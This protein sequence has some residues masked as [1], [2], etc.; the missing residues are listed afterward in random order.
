MRWVRPAGA[1]SRLPGPLPT[2]EV[3]PPTA[4]AEWLREADRP[5]ARPIQRWPPGIP[6][7]TPDV[8]G[9]ALRA[10]VRVL[11]VAQGETV[12]ALYV[13]STV[14]TSFAPGHLAL[15]QT[16]AAQAATGVAAGRADGRAARRRWARSK[17]RR[18][19]SRSRRAWPASSSWPG[20]Y[21]RAS[22]PRTFP[23]LPGYAFAAYNEPAREVGGDF[24]DVID[25]GDGRVGLVIADVS[26]KGMA[27]ALYMALS[28]SLIRAE[29]TRESSPRT[30]LG[31]V[32]RLLLEL[33][34]QGMFVTVFYGVLDGTSGHLIY[35]RAGHDHPLLLRDGAA[36][37]LAGKGCCLGSSTMSRA[38]LEETIRPVRRATGWC[39]TRMG[40]PT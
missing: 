20:R 32:N 29:A 11:L 33:G 21:S 27:A 38:G 6:W 15:L 1:P 5:A 22:C 3:C 2:E 17:Q 10:G 18:P 26:D 19:S 14:R 8:E 12:G 9:A 28:R 24:Y 40:S 35:A 13:H 37:P 36:Q 23:Q 25:L 39:C 30:V 16:F 7:R 31:N 34:E 4:A